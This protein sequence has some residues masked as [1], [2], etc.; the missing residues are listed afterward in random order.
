MVDTIKTPTKS[1]SS[2]KSTKTSSTKTSSS[3][4]KSTTTNNLSFS[5]HVFSSYQLYTDGKKKEDRSKEVK[6]ESQNGK[7]INGFISETINGKT[8]KKRI[9]NMHQIQQAGGATCKQI[10]TKEIDDFLQPS[11]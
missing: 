10:D 3:N 5:Y 11:L 1:A 8:N 9:T 4:K 6:I 7:K 2:K